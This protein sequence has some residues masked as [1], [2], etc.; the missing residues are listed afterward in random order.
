[1]TYPQVL[2]QNRQP[3]RIVTLEEYRESGGYSSLAEVVGKIAP[4]EVSLRVGGAVSG[5]KAY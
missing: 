1:M 4:R 3:D 2:F 5:A